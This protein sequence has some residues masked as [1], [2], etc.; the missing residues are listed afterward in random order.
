MG[1]TFLGRPC[2]DSLVTGFILRAKKAL[3]ATGKAI[4]NYFNTFSLPD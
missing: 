4:F 2:S 1:T 3:L